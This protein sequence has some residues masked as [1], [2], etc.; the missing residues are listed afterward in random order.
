[1]AKKRGKKGSK[2]KKPK[3]PQV[4]SKRGGGKRRG[5]VRP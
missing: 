4:I 2:R 5:A 1:M 3:E